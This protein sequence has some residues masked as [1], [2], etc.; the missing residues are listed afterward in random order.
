LKVTKSSNGGGR[1]TGAI[2]GSSTFSIEVIAIIFAVII[3]I[4]KIIANIV[5]KRK[6]SLSNY[7]N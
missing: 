2:I 7:S 3:L 5:N 4:G 1:I 6:P